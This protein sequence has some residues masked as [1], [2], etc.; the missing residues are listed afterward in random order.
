MSMQSTASNFRLYDLEYQVVSDTIQKIRWP[1][2]ND[3]AI[4]LWV[5]HQSPVSNE[6]LKFLL[7]Y[8]DVATVWYHDHSSLSCLKV[9]AGIQLLEKF[10]SNIWLV[11]TRTPRLQTVHQSRIEKCYDKNGFLR[12]ICQGYTLEGAIEEILRSELK[13]QKRLYSV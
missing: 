9:K 3:I 11:P 8:M 2:A 4:T 1:R 10:I 13:V 5:C 7:P 12:P 6:L